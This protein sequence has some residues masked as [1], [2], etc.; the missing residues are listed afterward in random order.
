MNQLVKITHDEDGYEQVN[1]KWHIVNNMG[2]SPRALCTGEVFGLGEGSA[3][4]KT[5]TAERG[6]TCPEC[7]VMIKFFKQVKL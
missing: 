4:Y 2:D 5:K 6:I 3:Q 1:P 7:I